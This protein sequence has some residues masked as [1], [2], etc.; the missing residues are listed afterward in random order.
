MSQPH[1]LPVG[2]ILGKTWKVDSFLG[3]GAC[4][5]VF[6]VSCVGSSPPDYPVVAKCIRTGSGNSKAAKEQERIANTLH[7]EYTLYAGLLLGFPHGPKLPRLGYGVDQ[8]VRFLVMERM[9][10]DLFEYAKSRPSGSAIAGI[11]LQILE[12]LQ[13]LHNKGFIFVDVKPENFMLKGSRV[14]FIDC[15]LFGFSFWY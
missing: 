11:G 15:K 12:G 10:Q 5:Q 7:Y 6:T 14:N 4:G 8:G 2:T 1:I 3:Q 9:D 13:W